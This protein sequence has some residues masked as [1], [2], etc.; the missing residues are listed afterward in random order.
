MASSLNVKLKLEFCI[1]STLPTQDSQELSSKGT[2]LA[3]FSFPL[4]LRTFQVWNHILMYGS[5]PGS[6]L[7]QLWVS[8]WN[9]YLHFGLMQLRLVVC[10]SSSYR[11]SLGTSFFSCLR[12]VPISTLPLLSVLVWGQRLFCH[13]GGTFPSL[14]YDLAFGYHSI[15]YKTQFYKCLLTLM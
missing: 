12:F 9:V 1:L 3:M 15:A 4:S 14:I 8:K 2:C 13:I 5:A 6:P 7:F 10:V 11:L